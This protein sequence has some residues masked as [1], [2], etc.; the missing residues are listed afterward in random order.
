[1]RGI[2]EVAEAS[3]VGGE[4][5]ANGVREAEV[6]V[7]RITSVLGRKVLTK[8]TSVVVVMVGQW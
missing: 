8:L 1:M 3:K 5:K 4:V 2:R 6:E 7:A